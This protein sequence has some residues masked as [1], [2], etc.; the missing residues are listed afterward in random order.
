MAWC[1]LIKLEINLLLPNHQQ[2]RHSSYMH[3]EMKVLLVTSNIGHAI[4]KYGNILS[5]F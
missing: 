2:Y 1:S 4:E 5:T 3:S